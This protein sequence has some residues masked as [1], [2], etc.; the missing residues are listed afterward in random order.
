MCN[1]LL[2]SVN[3]GNIRVIMPSSDTQFSENYQPKSRGQ[4]KRTKFLEALKESGYSEESFYKFC[5]DVAVGK[6]PDTEKPDNQLL[7][8][9]LSRL[10]TTPKQTLPV[11]EFELPSEGTKLQKADAII[12]AIGKGELPIDAGKML[13]DI[14]KDASVIEEVDDLAERIKI[15]EL[16]KEGK[17][18][19]TEKDQ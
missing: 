19:S 12:N 10:F 7:K 6:H 1:L 8:E 9:V 16:W 14:I 17:N 5:V 4:S 3:T 2:L 13:M 18:E 15:I 11:F